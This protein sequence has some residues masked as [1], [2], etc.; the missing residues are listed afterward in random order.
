MTGRLH[1]ISNPMFPVFPFKEHE[2]DL[3]TKDITYSEEIETQR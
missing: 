3:L 2:L 1:Y